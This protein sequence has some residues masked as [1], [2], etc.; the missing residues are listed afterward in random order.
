MNQLY[1]QA[2]QKGL[3]LYETWEYMINRCKEPYQVVWDFV[4]DHYND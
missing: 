1:H 3:G 2:Q 4:I